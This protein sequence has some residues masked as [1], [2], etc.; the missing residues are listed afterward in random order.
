MSFSITRPSLINRIAYKFRRWPAIHRVGR[1]LRRTLWSAVK[2]GFWEFTRCLFVN[3]TTF[4]PPA[5]TFSVYQALRCGWPRLNGRIVLHDQGVPQVA[6]D[7]LL[8]TS[9]LEQHLEQPWPILWSEHSNARLITES[10]ALLMPDKRLCAESAYNEKRWRTDT[11]SRFLRLP[12]PTRLDGNWTSMVSRWVPNRGFAI[13]GHWLHDALPRLALL[14]EFPSDTKIIVPADLKPYQ[15]ET[16]ELMGVWDR[17]R[18]TPERHLEI[19]HY[20]FSSPMS[21]IDGYNPYATHVAR[22]AFLPGDPNYS[23]PKKF[24]FHRTGKSR[25]IENSAEI[26]DFFRGKGWAIVNDVDLTFAQT[27]RLFS[28]ADAICSFV[29]SNMSNVI[30]CK[31]GC[32]VMHLVPDFWPDGWVDWIAQVVQADYHAAIIPC[33]GPF[34]H[35]IVIDLELIKKFFAAE[36][37]SF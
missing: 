15:K 5:R 11:A 8:V 6:G 23:G 31:P 13:Y 3:S 1:W 34:V 16:L 24:F 4:G 26:R 18:P 33:G 37:V 35:K 10:L 30:F 7:S 20:F 9:G 2:D 12:P 25:A 32:L 29:G 27:V 22:K 17:C 19:E 21:M 14:P 28:E 36:G